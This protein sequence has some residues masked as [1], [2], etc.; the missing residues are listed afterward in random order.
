[1]ATETA[2]MLID[3]AYDFQFNRT[4]YALPVRIL[5]EREQVHYG[6]IFCLA[7]TSQLLAENPVLDQADISLLLGRDVLSRHMPAWMRDVFQK[8]LR[9]NDWV[10][11]VRP[12]L[13]VETFA[14]T[15]TRTQERKGEKGRLQFTVEITAEHSTESSKSHEVRGIPFAKPAFL[16][17]GNYTFDAFAIRPDG[18]CMFYGCQ[19]RYGYFRRS[20]FGEQ[21]L[22]NLD[23]DPHT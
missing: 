13:A 21:I 15:K 22:D 4:A 11:Y 8:T 20:D 9:Q 18:A 1:V 12:Y 10:S 6:Y 5:S 3:G 19:G 23:S 14:L 17:P 7:R 16:N 2:A